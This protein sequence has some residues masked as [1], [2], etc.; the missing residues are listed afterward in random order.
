ME[1]PVCR[2]HFI[3]RLARLLNKL[4]GATA[5]RGCSRGSP[6]SLRYLARNLIVAW[7]PSQNGLFFDAPQ[8][9][10]VMRLRAS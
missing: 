4:I 3:T 5:P 7:V 6:P 8:R 10:T 9:Q 2:A 1:W